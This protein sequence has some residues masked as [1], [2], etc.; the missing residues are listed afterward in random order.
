MKL[1]IKEGVNVVKCGLTLSSRLL[2]AKSE[3]SSTDTAHVVDDA[4]S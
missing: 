1:K 2:I 3:T 4:H